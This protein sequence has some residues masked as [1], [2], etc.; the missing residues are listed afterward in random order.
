MI[1]TASGKVPL[2]VFNIVPYKLRI[3]TAS[4]YLCVHILSAHPLWSISGCSSGIVIVS[5]SHHSFRI[6]GTTHLFLLGVDPF[7]VMVQGHW[8]SSAFLEYW[9]HC[10]EII[11][12]YI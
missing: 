9:C 2:P 3:T 1:T 12:T 6:G 5:P 11:H 10:E 7:I 4:V 8:K